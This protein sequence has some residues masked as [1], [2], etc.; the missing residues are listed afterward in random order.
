M[1]YTIDSQ[2]CLG[3]LSL[4]SSSDTEK[5]FML[6]PRKFADKILK[7]HDIISDKT[8]TDKDKNKHKK[9]FATNSKSISYK[10]VQEKVLNWTSK[11]R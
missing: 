5:L 4:L 6:T 3:C 11:G 10:V 8:S 2:D 9:Q 7:N 1:H